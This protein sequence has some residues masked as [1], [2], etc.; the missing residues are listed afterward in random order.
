[1]AIRRVTGQGVS[2]AVLILVAVHLGLP[3]PRPNLFALEGMFRQETTY[4]YTV[5]ATPEGAGPITV[6]VPIPLTSG[7]LGHTQTIAL[8]EVV[9]DPRP[10]QQWEDTDG[11]GNPWA[12]VR[13]F[14][15]AGEVQLMRR[16]TC[17]EE[18]RYGPI[19][20][21]SPYPVA[22]SSLPWDV[23][24][25]L[26]PS[27]KVQATA[28]E[29]R[30]RALDLVSGTKT[31]LEAVA[32]ILSWVHANVRYACSKDLCDPVLRVDALFTL[33]KLVG[34][35][36]NFANLTLALLRAAGIPAQPVNGFVADR[37]EA[38]ASHAWVA[39]YFPDLGWVEWESSNWMPGYREVPVTFLLPQHITLFRGDGKGVSSAAFDEKHE[40]EFTITERPREV[41]EVRA[42]VRPGEAVAW[43]VTLRSPLSESSLFALVVEGAPSGWHAAVS[44]TAVGID[45]DGATRT[46]DV[47]LTIV[48]PA[49]ARVGA[50]AIVV[51]T[52]RAGGA[53]VGKFT[54]AVTVGA[55]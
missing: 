31:E 32:R 35:C 10:D 21:T 30:K 7:S 3:A 54:A 51:L 39:V 22:R 46:R 14:R 18:T 23:V 24:R 11:L 33:E 25:W 44:D 45:P 16:V 4:V 28:P 27:S 47:L 13:W 1:M 2:F 55:R 12:T 48:P 26:E 36:V 15:A 5:T 17:V 29:I 6:T 38:R 53:V 20:T 19:F 40:A 41:T 50:K 43:V 49:G 52:A 37:T 9:G 34:N 8:C 42:D